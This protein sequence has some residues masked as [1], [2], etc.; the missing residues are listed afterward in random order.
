MKSSIFI[1]NMLHNINYF[2]QRIVLAI[3]FVAV[4][5]K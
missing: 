2:E 3:N 1:K 4:I 5:L